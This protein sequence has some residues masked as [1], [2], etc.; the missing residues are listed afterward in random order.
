M[1]NEVE[2]IYSNQVCE[3]CKSICESG[4][5][6]TKGGSPTLYFCKSRCAKDYYDSEFYEIFR[7]KGV[8]LPLSKVRWSDEE[9]AKW[10]ADHLERIDVI[11]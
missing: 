9:W 7:A 2:V 3:N 11:N 1:E 8:Y 5:Y 4:S 10:Q 6:R